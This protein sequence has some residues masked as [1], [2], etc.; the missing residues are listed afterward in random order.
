MNDFEQQVHSSNL[1]T[2]LWCTFVGGGGG[3][4]GVGRRRMKGLPCITFSGF[5]YKK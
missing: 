4:G 5:S 3:G 1:V 2:L